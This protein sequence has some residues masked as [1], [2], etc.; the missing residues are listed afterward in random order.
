MWGAWGWQGQLCGLISSPVSQ[1]VSLIAQGPFLGIRRLG[2][3]SGNRVPTPARRILL[4][5]SA[6]LPQGERDSQEL[7]PV[8]KLVQIGE[9]LVVDQAEK[10]RTGRPGQQRTGPSHPSKVD[11]KRGMVLMLFPLRGLPTGG[12]GYQPTFQKARGTI[13]HKSDSLVVHADR[14]AQGFPPKRP[15]ELHSRQLAWRG[16]LRSHLRKSTYWANAIFKA[17]KIWAADRQPRQ[18]RIELAR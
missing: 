7:G 9:R 14:Q 6:R 16:W 1:K 15:V 18:N 12:G 3:N 17:S 4:S 5:K 10:H 11:L 2:L 8:N 13:H